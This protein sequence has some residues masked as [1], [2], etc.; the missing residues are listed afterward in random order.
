MAMVRSSGVR[1]GVFAFIAGC[2]SLSAQGAGSELVAYFPEWGVYQQPY[3]VRNLVTSGASSRITVLN[4]AF[5]I[6]APGPDGDV[7]CTLNDPE[8]AYLQA[9]SAG[10]AVDNEADTGTLRGHFNQLR[11]LKQ[12]APNVKILVALGGWTGSVWFSDAAIDAPSRQAFV[13]SCIKLFLDGNLPVV[14]GMGGAGSAAGIF[15]GFDIDWEYPITGGDTGVHHSASD[16]VNLTALLAEFRA[17]LNAWEAEHRASPRL[18]TMAVPASD[19]RGQ[20]YQINLDQQYV[21]WF[22]LMSY[23]FHGTWE[24][25]TGHLTNLLSSADDPSSDAFKMSLDATV[26]LYRDVYGVPVNK[27]VGGAAFYGRGWKNVSSSNN[28]L[29]QSGQAASGVYEAGANYW[30]DLAP[31]AGQ[32]YSWFWDDK[33]LAAWLYS[34]GAA[35]FWTLDDPQ[36]LALKSRYAKAYGLRGMMLWEISGDDAGGSLLA[37]LHTGN[38]G[39][40]VPGTSNVSGPTVAITRPADCA[41]SLQGFNQVVNATAGAGTAQVGFFANGPH[42]L[43]FDNRGPWS[44]AWFNLPAGDHE[45]VAVATD[46]NGDYRL[47]SPVRLTVYGADS[48]VDLWQT[49]VTYTTGDEVFYEGCIYASKRTHVGSRVRLPTSDRYW[50]LVTCSDCGGGGGGGNGQPPTVDLISP[51]NGASFTAPASIS[52]SATAGDT[53][54]TINRV[55]FY[56]S[57]TLLF[58]DTVSPYG[59]TWSN[60]AAGSYTLRAV[61]VD[62]QGNTAEDSVSVTV[63]TAGGCSLPAW[64]STTTYLQG[65]LV[66]HKGIKW[67]AKRESV[68]V[69]PGTNPAKWTNLGTCTT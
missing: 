36:S 34:P 67:K 42:S 2:F 55:D 16:D 21:D 17:Q 8:A 62:N 33:A 61:A 23:D 43:G 40:E 3:L 66:Q 10:M 38:P 7:V 69:E 19:F 57:T 29:Y 11:K 58:S 53:D 39:A 1:Q 4:Y 9:Y 32:D 47:S 35:T 26:R 46:N 51:A 12:I 52:L 28:G 37:A 13:N 6:P 60:V 44:W 63:F 30:R 18:L 68:G 41:I 5:A 65:A 20:N 64:N 54:G 25:S 27:L 50:T 15:D 49:G 45:L 31:L 56:Q 59:F 24:N 14:N 48:G 22:N